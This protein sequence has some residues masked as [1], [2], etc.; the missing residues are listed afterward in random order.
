MGLQYY[1]FVS[2]SM[3]MTVEL[4]IRWYSILFVGILWVFA[5][6]HTF[7]FYRVSDSRK[8]LLF[9]QIADQE[10]SLANLE[11]DK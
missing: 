2:L 10:R 7:V 4:P 8:R 5:L 9:D 6:G 1:I 11:L 3:L